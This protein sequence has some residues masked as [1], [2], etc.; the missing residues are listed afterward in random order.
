VCPFEI[1]SQ[2]QERLFVARANFTSSMDFSA[3]HDITIDNAH[4]DFQD[5]EAVSDVCDIEFD[6]SE[7]ESQLYIAELTT[8]KEASP[9]PTIKEKLR[10]EWNLVEEIPLHSFG[11]NNLRNPYPR[12]IELLE[13]FH[14]K[15]QHTDGTRFFNRQQ[16]VQPASLSLVHYCGARARFGCAFEAKMCFKQSPY[17][18]AVYRSLEH[19]HNVDLHSTEAGKKSSK[20]GAWG[21]AHHLRPFIEEK[22]LQNLSPKEIHRAIRDANL[23]PKP[24]I[25]QLQNFAAKI[26]KTHQTELTSEDLGS[27]VDWV[28]SNPYKSELAD[29]ELFVLPDAVLP[30]DVSWQADVKQKTQIVCALSTKTLLHNAVKQQDSFVAAFLCIDGTYNLLENSWP[31][32]VI[33]TVDLNHHFRLIAIAISSAEDEAAFAAVLKGI[34]S[35]I[36]LCFPGRN[37]SAKF[38]MQDGSIAI[39]NAT[40]LELNPKDVLSCWFHVKQQVRK[41]KHEF[42]SVES[43]QEFNNDLDLLQV[44]F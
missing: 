35:G 24:S 6:E 16:K 25:Q 12:C 3:N 14:S 5:G 23:K 20:S 9:A 15:L 33:G 41:R 31:C 44:I 10:R 17:H 32:L 2:S 29:D 11:A 30:Q 43:F 22:V 19:C 40:R 13:S 37:L 34:S 21:I 7:S 39:Y 8:A 38:T 28:R 4:K 36:S 18:C 42:Q 1:C 27:F 26:R